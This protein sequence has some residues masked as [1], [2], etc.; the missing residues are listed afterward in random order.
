M[1]RLQRE[2]MPSSVLSRDG[3]PAKVFHRRARL[4]TLGVWPKSPGCG[5]NDGQ[6]PF[7]RLAPRSSAERHKP[8]FSAELL[9]ALDVRSERRQIAGPPR[10][11]LGRLQR[12]L[13][14]G[15][16]PGGRENFDPDR[17]FSLGSRYL[18]HSLGK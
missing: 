8:T 9:G 12:S 14:C 6:T 4:A 1:R 3:V 17:R 2:P 13:V 7:N 10:S 16:G 11:M 15:L 18:P 5:S